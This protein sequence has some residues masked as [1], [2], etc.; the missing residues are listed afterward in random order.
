MFAVISVLDLFGGS[1]K[2]SFGSNTQL[3][4]TIRV[5]FDVGM[6]SSCDCSDHLTGLRVFVL[7]Q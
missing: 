5:R 3:Q 6:L 2:V 1:V 4:E 7:Q